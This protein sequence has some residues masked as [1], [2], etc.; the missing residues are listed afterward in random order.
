NFFLR[1]DDTLKFLHPLRLRPLRRRALEEAERWM[2]ERIGEGSDGLAAVY[3][4]MLNCLIAL[5]ALGYSK[6]N[7]VYAKA[8]KDFAGLFVDDHED[9]RIQPCLAP[10]WD[11]AI[12]IISL[13]D[14]GV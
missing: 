13:A 8:E 7:A 4:A 3:P 10:V 14:S 5:R 9:F 12:T 11:T 6:R 1:V 2:L